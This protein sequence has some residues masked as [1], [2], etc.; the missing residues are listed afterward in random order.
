M[1]IIIIPI[2]L[3]ALILG[4]ISIAKTFKQLKRSQITIK[5]LIFGLL[6]AG[7]IFGLICLSYIME[8]SAW[9]LSPA[10]RIPIFMIFIPFAIQIATENSG[11]YKLLYFSKIILVSIAITTILGVI[12]NDLIFGLIDYLGIEKT[13]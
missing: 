3:L 12:F 4:I 6:F 5:E 11:N 7:T 10:F 9:G 2:L 8:G 1:G 13:Y